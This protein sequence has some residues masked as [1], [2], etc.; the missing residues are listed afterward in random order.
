MKG[1]PV[2]ALIHLGSTVKGAQQNACVWQ[3]AWP[4]TREV[5]EGD[6]DEG[7]GDAMGSQWWS[8]STLKGVGAEDDTQG[9]ASTDRAVRGRAAEKG[10]TG[11]LDGRSS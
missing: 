1:P 2:S 11:P 6:G 3:T 5:G 7:V 4:R 8:R 10:S 9:S